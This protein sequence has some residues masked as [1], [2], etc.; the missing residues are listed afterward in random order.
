MEKE[1][2]YRIRF[3]NGKV[4]FIVAT[5]LSYNECEEVVKR[6]QEPSFYKIEKLAPGTEN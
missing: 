6:Q 2:F 5:D 3:N 4:N 1:D